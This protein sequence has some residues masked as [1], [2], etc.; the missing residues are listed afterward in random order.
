MERS[1]TDRL[2]EEHSERLDITQETLDFTSKAYGALSDSLV[3]HFE[4]IAEGSESVGTA[5]RA[6]PSEVLSAIGK[7]SAVKALFYVAE[8]IASIVGQQYDRAAESF[9]AAGVYA[10]VATL[11]LGGGAALAPSKTAATEIGRAHV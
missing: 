9:A 2:R 5:L 7:E 1:F 4:A 3:K 6:V 10:A 8:G 11:A